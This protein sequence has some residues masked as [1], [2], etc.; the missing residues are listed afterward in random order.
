[1]AH[2]KSVYKHMI[3]INICVNREVSSIVFKSLF[4]DRAV[5]NITLS[6]CLF[7]FINLRT[8]SSFVYIRRR[9]L[10]TAR[11]RGLVSNLYLS[12]NIFKKLAVGGTLVGFV[13]L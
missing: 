13:K 7:S 6:K 9:C 12:R 1:M 10:F 11:G 4:K 8:V 2:V 3:F 5:S